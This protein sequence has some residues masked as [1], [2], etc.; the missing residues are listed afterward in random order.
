[1]KTVRLDAEAIKNMFEWNPNFRVIHF[2]RDPR[3]VV[4]SRLKVAW[5]KHFATPTVEIKNATECNPN[6]TGDT[7][8]NGLSEHDNHTLY[9]NSFG[10]EALIPVVGYEARLY[11]DWLRRDILTLAS[12]PRPLSDQVFQV[13]YG[14]L[15]E[16]P[17]S[18]MNDLHYFLD[19]PFGSNNLEL[20]WLKAVKQEGGESQKIAQKWMNE[21]SVA[22]VQEINR[23]CQALFKTFRGSS[24][25]MTEY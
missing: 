20:A 15:I 10:D 6:G 18:V 5:A 2:F 14:E 11:C 3:P 24:W 13:E 9:V 22:L 4:L 8:E 7:K 23:Q 19:E 25:K 16:D 21:L 12:L 17:S 1:M